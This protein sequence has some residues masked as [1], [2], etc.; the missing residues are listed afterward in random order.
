[1]FAIKNYYATMLITWLVL[2]SV[3]MFLTL[4]HALGEISLT[5]W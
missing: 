1:M 2:A 4:A 5:L 3:V